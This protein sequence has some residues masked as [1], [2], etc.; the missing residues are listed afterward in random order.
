MP[1]ALAI[2]TED[3]YKRHHKVSSTTNIHLLVNLILFILNKLLKFILIALILLKNINL[4]LIILF[5]LYLFNVYKI[6]F[7]KKK[8]PKLIYK[9][10]SFINIYLI[11]TKLQHVFLDQATYHLL[12]SHQMPCRIL[13]GIV[14][15]H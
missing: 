14:I 5:V 9:V 4:Y 11:S 7:Y 12:A 3:V 13:L 2:P 15:E 6:Y 10:S 1:I 8:S